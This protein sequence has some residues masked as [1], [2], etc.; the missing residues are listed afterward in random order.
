MKKQL[1]V[2]RSVVTASAGSTGWES[3]GSQGNTMS[4]GKPDWS[5]VSKG[6]GGSAPP[7]RVH[8]G[9]PVG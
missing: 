3:P 8:D 1:I 4:G 7:H 5:T 2:V 9:P 6:S